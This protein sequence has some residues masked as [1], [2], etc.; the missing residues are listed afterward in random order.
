MK[1][2]NFMAIGKTTVVLKDSVKGNPPPIASKLHAVVAKPVQHLKIDSSRINIRHLNEPALKH[3]AND[4]DFDYYQEKTTNMSV[5]DRFWNW[6]WHLLQNPKQGEHAK[7]SSP[8]IGYIFWAII[9]I[10]ILVA[11]I[12]FATSNGINI[13]NRRSMQ[14]DLLNTGVIENIHEIS[15]DNEIEKARADGNYRLA[16]RLLYL[17]ALK[18]L[19]DAGLINWRIEKTNSAYLNELSDAEQRQVFR[20]ITRQFEYVWY[21]EFAIDG[22]SFQNIHQLFNHFKQMLP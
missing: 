14:V 18:Q 21:G 22:A 12:K 15:F 8:Y 9:G 10:I 20:A 19:N 3:F 2:I 16:I 11:I 4:P 1:S 7:Y 13:F 5:W 6:V 17:R